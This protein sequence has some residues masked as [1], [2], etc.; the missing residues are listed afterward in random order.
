VSHALLEPQATHI[1][2]S[3]GV[4]AVPG[5]VAWGSDALMRLAFTQQRLAEAA[6]AAGAAGGDSGR[7]A[8][9]GAGAGRPPSRAAAAAAGSGDIIVPFLSLSYGYL[10]LVWGATLSHYI[11]ALLEEAG[12]ILP[13]TAATFGLDGA[14]LPSLVADHAVTQFLQVRGVTCCWLAARQA[15][16]LRACTTLAAGQSSAYHGASQPVHCKQGTYHA[17]LHAGVCLR[18]QQD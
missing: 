9:A 4:M 11:P 8:L 16:T 1:L 15:T 18:C 17:V 10:P 7:L 3:V 6:A 14:G 2:A 12:L 5:L 13:V